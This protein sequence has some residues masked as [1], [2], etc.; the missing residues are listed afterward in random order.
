MKS[1]DLVMSPQTGLRVVLPYV[2]VGSLYIYFSDHLLQLFSSNAAILSCLQTLKGLAFILATAGL[3]LLLVQAHDK[4]IAAHYKEYVEDLK[5]SEEELLRSEEKYWSIFN[6]SPVPM[7]IFDETNLRFLLVNETACIKYGY[8]KEEFYCMGIGN[9][10]PPEDM[11]RFYDALANAKNSKIMS[12]QRPF[13]H[14]TKNGDILLVKIK[15]TGISFEG[16]ACRLVTAM[17][18]T[19]EMTYQME[20]K[21]A[22]ERL[23]TASQIA[24]L[25]YWSRD[26]VTAEIYWSEELYKIFELSPEAFELSP[27]NIQN[28]FHPDDRAQFDA[29]LQE[30]FKHNEIRESEQRIVMPDGRQKWIVQRLKLITG[31]DNVPLKLEGVALDITERKKTQQAVRESNERFTMVTKA[32]VEAIIDWNVSQGEVFLSDGFRELFGH[33]TVV[34]DSSLWLNYIHPDDRDRVIADLKKALATSAQEYFYVEFR[35][36]KADGEVAYVEHRGIFVR[37]EKGRVVRAVGAMID[38]TGSVNKMQKIEQQNQ[39][40]REITWIQSHI[41]RGPLATLMGLTSM[42]QENDLLAT[43]REEMLA[44]ITACANKLDKVIHDI[45]KKAEEATE[46]PV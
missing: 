13:R 38:V 24:M 22:N 30:V 14:I 5:R 23:C 25:G 31:D 18:V 40:L 20:L 7:W 26:L 29:D 27:E 2:L 17:D 10:R 15:S 45:V 41:V 36:L 19:K 9:I 4:R 8:S 44:G 34:N 6:E 3:L 35:F 33:N 32:A 39:K 12:W 16:K 46:Y 37:N 43:E 11:P 1:K 21:L 28:R 42:L